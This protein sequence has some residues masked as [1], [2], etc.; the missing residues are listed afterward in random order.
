MHPVKST[1]APPHKKPR[2]R[3]GQQK[4][5]DGYRAKAQSLKD[6]RFGKTRVHTDVTPAEYHKKIEDNALT[7]E[8][9]LPAQVIKQWKV[10]ND[11][12]TFSRR[13]RKSAECA[14]NATLKFMQERFRNVQPMLPDRRASSSRQ[15]SLG[16]MEMVQ[17]TGWEDVNEEENEITDSMKNLKV[18]EFPVKVQTTI[19]Q[20][21]VDNHITILKKVIR[22]SEQ[23]LLRVARSICYK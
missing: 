16:S 22:I 3:T 2:H 1:S 13:I 7:T 11:Q 6:L 15:S 18:V 14:E 10:T 4:L 8:D 12:E 21:D 5:H 23:L 19:G 20:T 17:A 9:M